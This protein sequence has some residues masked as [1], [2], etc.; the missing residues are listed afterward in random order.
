MTHRNSTLDT[1]SIAALGSDLEEVSKLITG[2]LD[3][4]T[5]T[6]HHYARRGAV[7]RQSDSA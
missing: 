2:A 5:W 4:Q 7:D 6:I 1:N 3:Q